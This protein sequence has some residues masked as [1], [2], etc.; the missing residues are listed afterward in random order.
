MLGDNPAFSLLLLSALMI[1]WLL[2]LSSFL[3]LRGQRDRNASIWFAGAWLYAIVVTMFAFTS[4]LPAW[5]SGPG[6]LLLAT[7]SVLCFLEAMRRE[8]APQE[9]AP[10]RAYAALA[11]LEFVLL[12]A[13]QF[14]RADLFLHWGRMVHLLL[15]AVLDLVVAVIALKV[16]RR[17]GGRALYMVAAVFLMFVCANFIR[18]MEVAFTGSYSELRSFTWTASLGVLTNYLGGIFYCYGYWG[19]VTEK[20]R[21]KEMAALDQAVRAREEERIAQER[22]A[23][24]EE[25]LATR[26]AMMEQVASMG[27][28]A[29]AGALSASLAHE[30]SQPLSSALLNVEQALFFA[31][32]GQGSPH[33][34]PLLEQARGETMRASDSL[35]RVKEMFRAG[36][37]RRSPVQPDDVVRFAVAMMERQLTE[38]GIRLEL[39]L[40]ADHHVMLSPGELEH[41]LLNLLSNAVEALSGQPEALRQIEVATRQEGGRFEL[42]FQDHGPGVEGALAE[43][44]FDMRYT[45]K[46]ANT[47]LGLWLARYIVERH[48]GRIWLEQQAADSE[49]GGPRGALFRVSLPLA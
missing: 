13:L 49:G 44:I 9:P 41:V 23:A 12:L 15:V 40:Q 14:W 11:G 48:L 4:R 46:S 38:Q 26:N 3:M 18:S 29:Q 25:T 37:P 43:R 28:M 5:L 45:T 6:L 31:G 10:L 35:R 7:T 21:D 17:T 16:R 39:D 8:W 36:A 22:K 33:L 2:P 30:I 19:F 20:V 34:G 42:Y 1:F 47:G 32:Q 27:K 24:A